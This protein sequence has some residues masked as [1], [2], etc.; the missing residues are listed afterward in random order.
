MSVV[1]SIKYFPALSLSI[2]IENVNNSLNLRKRV[3]D[4]NHNKM[5]DLSLNISM[6]KLPK[7]PQWLVF[8]SGIFLFKA[9]QDWHY[10]WGALQ[11]DTLLLS[12]CLMAAV[13]YYMRRQNLKSVILLSLLYIYLG[14]ISAFRAGIF[15][16]V[17]VLILLGGLLP[18]FRVLAWKPFWVFAF[19]YCLLT[20]SCFL[21][22]WEIITSPFS[23]GYSMP[24]SYFDV[25]WRTVEYPL[26]VALVVIHF[27]G[28]LTF[29]S[30]RNQ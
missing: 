28:H 8:G 27:C 10:P 4:K 7:W 30:D 17:S 5:P 3:S 29:S 25:T 23:H 16:E 1:H 21:A 2:V 22:N 12:I 15:C 11:L 24:V 20:V 9:F 18:A 26:Y 14:F 19:S 13:I 6:L